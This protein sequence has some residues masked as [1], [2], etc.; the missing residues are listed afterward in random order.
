MNMDILEKIVAAKRKEVALKKE[1]I[2]LE[3][4]ELLPCF[5]RNCI[6]LSSRLMESETGIIAEFKRRSPSVPNINLE[7]EIEKIPF[8]YEK[9]GAAGISILTDEEFFGGSNDDLF[10]A[11]ENVKIPI[12]RKDFIIDEYQ[13]YESKAIGADVILLIAALLSKN[14]VKKFAGIAE[15]LG[16]E[17]LFEVHNEKELEKL[18]SNIKMLGVNNRNLKT[19]KVDINTSKKLSELIPSEFIKVSESGIN[20]IENIMELKNESFQGFLL[21]EYFMKTEDPGKTAAEFIRKLS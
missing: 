6:S 19:F 12:L 16:L 1:M 5:E 11:R 21:G 20:S 10:I 18:S 3:A 7:A 8:E 17:V 13:I 2:P 15:K 9:A 14:E 4:L